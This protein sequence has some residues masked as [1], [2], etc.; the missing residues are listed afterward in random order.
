MK[1]EEK[2]KYD[3]L[4]KF[5]SK[6]HNYVHYIQ[7]CTYGPMYANGAKI[8]FCMCSQHNATQY[9]LFKKKLKGCNVYTLEF[10]K[11]LGG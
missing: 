3:F 1:V 4:C 2:N 8:P 7:G 10:S 5:A 6:L 9:K 11:V